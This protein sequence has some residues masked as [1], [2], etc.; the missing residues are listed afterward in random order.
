LNTQILYQ[1]NTPKFAPGIVRRAHALKAA[2]RKSPATTPVY[3]AFIENANKND[4]VE[5]AP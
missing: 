5:K 3:D 1:L 2:G 4:M